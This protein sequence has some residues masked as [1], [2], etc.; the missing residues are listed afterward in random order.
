MEQK[1]RATRA[2]KE[3]KG[4]EKNVEAWQ[5]ICRFLDAADI[6]PEDKL[7]VLA[8][9]KVEEAEAKRVYKEDS[10]FLPKT[11]LKLVERYEKLRLAIA[12]QKQANP[13]TQPSTRAD[14]EREEKE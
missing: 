13:T 9:V 10:P 4:Y 3:R 1:R 8:R 7:E 12:S 2:A 14:S 5:D 6:P 11:Y